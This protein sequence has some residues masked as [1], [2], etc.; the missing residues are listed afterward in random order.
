MGWGSF[1]GIG[2]KV[3]VGLI[4]PV[5][6][7]AKCQYCSRSRLAR[8]AFDWMQ[9]FKAKSCFRQSMIVSFSFSW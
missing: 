2:V 8:R 1:V 3:G 6:I 7:K 9:S 4:W 5:F